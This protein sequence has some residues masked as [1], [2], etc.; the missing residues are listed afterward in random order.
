MAVISVSENQEGVIC[1]S[2]VD[3]RYLEHLPILVAM[4]IEHH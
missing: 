3:H 1:N 2:M 4:A